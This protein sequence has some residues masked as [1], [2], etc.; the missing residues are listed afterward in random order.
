[1]IL[2]PSV[3]LLGG[4][5]R[6]QRVGLGLRGDAHPWRPLRLRLLCLLRWRC[7]GSGLRL[8]LLGWLLLLLLRYLRRWLLLLVLLL[9]LLLLWWRRRRR[10]RWQRQRGSLLL[11]R[12]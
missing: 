2:R 10:W 8:G 5:R 11:C 7:G 4:G 9:L 3:L 12:L 1:M 6:L